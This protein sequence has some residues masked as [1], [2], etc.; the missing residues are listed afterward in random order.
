MGL[1]NDNMS[2]AVTAELPPRSSL[3]DRAR[4]LGRPHTLHRAPSRRRQRASSSD[5]PARMPFSPLGFCAPAGPHL[6]PSW[7]WYRTTSR[8]IDGRMDDG[9]TN[10][11]MS[12]SLESDIAPTSRAAVAGV[13]MRAAGGR[14]CARL[15][16][17]TP[18][19]RPRCRL[20]RP[21]RLPPRRLLDE[22]LR[23]PFRS[24]PTRP[25][26]L[27]PRIQGIQPTQV[28]FQGR[29]LRALRS[30]CTGLFSFRK[31]D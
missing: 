8:R 15:L 13:G 31:N 27:T 16:A 18:S 22:R 2:W 30:C 21:V 24:L 7:A 14:L 29:R 6:S 19:A 5:L 1:R 28:F 10:P 20:R 23:K 17:Q 26:T 25:K 3:D 4:L 9:D 11:E 12:S